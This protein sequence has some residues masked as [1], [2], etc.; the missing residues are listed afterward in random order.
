MW[1]DVSTDALVYFLLAKSC[2]GLSIRSSLSKMSPEN[3]K[4]GPRR[5]LRSAYTETQEIGQN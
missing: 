4:I 2:K 5:Q 1:F 3:N